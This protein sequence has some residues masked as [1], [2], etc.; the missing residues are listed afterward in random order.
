MSVHR[1]RRAFTQI[2]IQ[3]SEEDK[4]VMSAETDQRCRTFE[5]NR[6]RSRR[7]TRRTVHAAGFAAVLAAVFAS[8]SPA[9]ADIAVS[10]SAKGGELRGGR[11]ILRGVSGRVSW[12]DV[13]DANSS[14]TASVRRMHRRLFRPGAPVTGVLHIA[15]ARD[16]DE[17]SFRLSKPR[18]SAPRRTVSYNAEPLHTQPQ[19]SAVA[20]AATPRRFGAASLSIVSSVASGGRGGNDCEMAF[21]NLTSAPYV[22]GNPIKLV[23]AEKW[24]TDEWSPAPPTSLITFHHGANFRSEGGLW[25]GC[26]QSTVWRFFPMCIVGSGCGPEGTFTF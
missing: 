13:S 25:R 4:P 14:G 15:G 21:T 18:Y 12:W 26:S 5:Q 17:P 22:Q 2:R 16:S 19:S 11:L 10:H 6:D 8:A 20:H 1:Q 24:D 3:P 9:S 7:R 23:S